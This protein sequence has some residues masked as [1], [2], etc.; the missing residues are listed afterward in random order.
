MS[1]IKRNGTMFPSLP[2][3]FDDFLSREPFNWHNN[4]FSS[5]NTTLP[6]VNIKEEPGQFVVELAAPGMD[7]GDFHITLENNT[8][9]I[10]SEKERKEDQQ[11]NSGFMRREFSYDSFVRT[12][13]LPK[14][15][16]NESGIVATYEH[17]ILSVTI[18]KRE[19]AKQKPRRLIEIN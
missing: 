6:A 2:S 3:L 13:V 16:V 12:F 9:T 17:G 18:P 10:Q 11:D 5:T 14:E 15:I 8:L 19:E 1:I 4:N 7:K